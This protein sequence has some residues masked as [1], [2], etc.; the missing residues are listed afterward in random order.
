[1]AGKTVELTVNTN[2]T[3]KEARNVLVVPLA[4]ESKLY[5]YNWVQNN[6]R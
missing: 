3:E 5:Y 1:M 6:I 4:D 2:P